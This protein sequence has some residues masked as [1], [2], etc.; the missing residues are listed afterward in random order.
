MNLAFG[1]SKTALASV[2]LASLFVTGAAS[3]KATSATPSA[4][5]YDPKIVASD[6]VRSVDNRYFPL[7]PGTTYVFEGMVAKDKIHID[8]VVTHDTKKILGIDAV[9]VRDTVTTNGKLSEDTYDW[10]AQDKKGDVWYLGEDSKV[11]KD[12][13][14]TSTEGSWEAGVDNAKPGIIMQANPVVGDPYRQEYYA[15]H[16]EDMAQITKVGQSAKVASGSYTDVVVINEWSALDPKV[17]ERK[18]Y[19]PGIGNISTESTTESEHLALV[20]ITVEPAA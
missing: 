11:Y 1:R 12:G 7:K 9:V 8:V 16:A 17:I 2:L 19:A 3:A 4:S 15:T 10:Y 5:S 18:A 14:V 13:K 20:S 6:F